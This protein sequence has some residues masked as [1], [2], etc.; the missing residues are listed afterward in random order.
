MSEKIS[1]REFLKLTGLG[2]A[3]TAVLTGCGPASRYV[4]RRPYTELPEYHQT[5]VSTYFATTC[6]ECAAG[7]GIIMRTQEGRAIKA[8]GNPK[9]PVNRGKICSKGLT[10]VQGLYNPDR[11]KGP[12]KAASRGSGQYQ[13]MEWDSAITVVRNGLVDPGGVAFLMGS[14][15]DHLFDLVTEIATGVGA[16]APVRYDAED[17]F[18]AEATLI[19]A[20]QNTFGQAAYPYFDLGGA[21]LAL[22]FG[23]DFSQSWLSPVAYS[24]MYGRFR[25]GNFGRRGYLIAFEPFQSATSSV[26]DEWYPV[27]PGTEGMVALAIARLVIDIRGAA[28]FPALDAVDPA[29]AAQA[30]G[31]SLERLEHVARLF[32][33]AAAPLSMPGQSALATA[34]GLANAQVILSLNALANNLGRAGG[35]FLHPAQVQ[36]GS[37]NQVAALVERMRSGQVKTLFIHGVNPVFELPAAL[38]FEQAMQQVQTV[39]SFSSYPDETALLSDYV[40]PD[41]TG[42]ESWGYMRDLAG[43][44]RTVV[45][46]VQPV[47]VP[48]YNTRATADVFIEAAK[49]ANVAG[50]GYADEV[51]FLQQKLLP[52]MDQGGSFTAPEILSFWTQWL[53]NGGWWK[54]DTDLTTPAADALLDQPVNITAPSALGDN[55]FYLLTYAG[56]LGSGAVA[57]RPWMQETPDTLTTVMWNSVVLVNPETAH[58]LGI[59]SDDVITLAS[60]AGSLDAVVYEYPAIRPDMVAIPFGQGHTALGRWAEGRGVNPAKLLGVDLNQAGDLAYYGGTRVTITPTGR[61]RPVSRLESEAGVYGHK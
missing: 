21:D 53:Q 23:A 41:H 3:V 20:V 16:A 52:L 10:S 6:R 48:L 50:I 18:S 17:M 43:A 8:E 45:S 49:R 37:M 12:Q 15:S 28:G 54:Q 46:A 44:D 56:P 32:A 34:Q 14:G 11:V 26:A 1:R 36:P 25:K 51:D 5:G 57:N 7:C 42:L 13:T 60:P 38:G 31:I 22:S 47:V 2:A 55:E 39:V 30:A 35:V 40:F 24:R 27:V 19:Q 61:R 33:N 29:A 4:V 59:Q 58:R 9:H